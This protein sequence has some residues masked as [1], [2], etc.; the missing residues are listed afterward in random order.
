M[1]D[2]RPVLSTTLQPS[3]SDRVFGGNYAGELST[4]SSE[5]GQQLLV[6]ASVRVRGAGTGFFGAGF[7]SEWVLY[8]HVVRAKREP[9]LDGR[10]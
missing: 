9:L 10:C 7:W 3:P 1:T 5:A 4:I 8:C 6:S 2:T